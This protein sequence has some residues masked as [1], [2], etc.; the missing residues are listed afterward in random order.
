MQSSSN[1]EH[2]IN[3]RQPQPRSWL[4]WRWVIPVAILLASL[5]LRRLAHESPQFVDHYYSHSFYLILS[6]AISRVSGLVSFSL[7]EALI[8]GLPAVGL[9]FVL[10]RTRR[11]LLR[12]DSGFQ[13]ALSRTC[14]LIWVLAVAFAVFQLLFG[15]N[16]QRP[17]LAAGLQLASRPA[18]QIEL[19]DI[20]LLIIAE[21]NHNFDEAQSLGHTRDE[22]SAAIERAYQAADL[23]GAPASA[24]FG[25]PKP[26]YASRIMTRLGISG[27]Y[28]P[29]TGEPNI[30][31][32]QPE[33]E[34]PFS[35]AHEKAHQRGYAREDE[36][37]F[38]AF[39]VCTRS[40]SPFVRYSGFSRGLRVLAPLRAAVSPERY[41]EIVDQ[42]SPGV[43]KDLQ[44][45]AEFWRIARHP[46]L[47]KLADRT[48]NTYLRANG[49][50]SGTANY[51]EVVSLIIGYY[52]T[53]PSAPRQAGTGWDS[54]TNRPPESGQMK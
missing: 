50:S 14:E 37:S 32:N 26:V 35:I 20:A 30:N 4:P 28:S 36:A 11:Q 41:H 2:S 54:P 34:L 21:V 38:V 7:G 10:W 1:L 23:L 42:L 47:E 49:V 3:S 40:D 25:P 5:A 39:L 33:S 15:L 8:V 18:T 13:I 16:Y 29:F 44:K 24:R 43:R 19:E 31:T 22:V 12:G 53:Y 9:F 27:I 46:M 51:G 6:S 45:N 52:L 48:N 17:P